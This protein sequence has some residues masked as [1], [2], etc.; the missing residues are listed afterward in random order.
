MIER[1]SWF[2]E[3]YRVLL[4]LA[5]SLTI[6]YLLG[7]P[8][9]SFAVGLAFVVSLW[10]HQLWRIQKWLTSTETEPPDSFGIWGII[11]DRIYLLQRRN[12]EARGRLQS[13]LDYMQDSMASMRDGVIMLDNSAAI[14]WCNSATGKLLGL[15]FPEDSGQH[16]LNLIRLPEFHDYFSNNDYSRALQVSVTGAME[17]HLRFE[18]THFGDGNRLVFVRDVTATVRLEQVRRD[19]VGNVSHELRTPLTVIKGYLETLIGSGGGLDERYQQALRQMDQQASRMESLLKDL[20][21][22]S[23]IESM[24]KEEK[25]ELIDVAGLLE[26]LKEELQS[27][28]PERE[29]RFELLCKNPVQG[30]YRE[31]HSAVSN[32]VYNALKYSEGGSP[33]TVRWL[34]TA[35]ESRLE[36]EDQGIGIDAMHIPRLTERFYRVDESR[37]SQTGGT[38]LGLAIVKHVAVSHD[39]ELRIDSTRGKGSTFSLIFPRTQLP[40]TATGTLP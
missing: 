12:R 30:D 9:E 5:V 15:R 39:A 6:G 10:L 29:I 7:Y 25:S 2:R 20:L 13:A 22:L 32:L 18:I 11:Y 23:R 17:R 35:G 33:V 14:E 26:E 34:E 1:Q 24:D 31:L 38:G 40:E 16:V 37:S 3:L 8:L 4:F 36:V 19:F 27:N 21:W 28:F